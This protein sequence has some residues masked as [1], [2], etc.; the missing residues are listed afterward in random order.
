MTGKRKPGRPKGFVA[1]TAEKT[2]VSKRAVQLD[3]ERGEKIAPDVLM[4]I[5]GTRLDK[6]RYLDA[7]KNLS[8]EDQRQRVE[9]DLRHGDCRQPRLSPL[10]RL[11][12]AWLGLDDD[13]RA[14]FRDWIE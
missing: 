14:A 5:R 10:D 1:E 2:G 12:M 11:K 7:I 8:H 3:V 6:G 9:H 4:S 13:D